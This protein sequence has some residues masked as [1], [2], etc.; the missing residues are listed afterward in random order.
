VS[1]KSPPKQDNPDA[2]S[3]EKAEKPKSPEKG[4]LTY[5]RM[6]SLTAAEQSFYL[7]ARYGHQV[8]SQ[9]QPVFQRLHPLVLAEQKEFVEWAAG[10]A[11]KMPPPPLHK[12]LVQQGA[13]LL[14]ARQEATLALSMKV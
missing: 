11:H 9:T 8:S 14:A 2:T 3:P 13:A 10:V 1:N 7:A 4:V 6:S 12:T 5:P